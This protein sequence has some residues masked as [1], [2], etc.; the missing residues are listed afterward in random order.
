MRDVLLNFNN[1]L[2]KN[3]VKEKY[4]AKSHFIS[5]V[6]DIGDEYSSMNKKELVPSSYHN[7]HENPRKMM[8]TSDIFVAFDDHDGM[9]ANV[10]SSNDT[11]K[12]YFVQK[13]ESPD[14]YNLLNTKT[15]E[16]E[17]VA[18]VD[19]MKT[20]KMLNVHFEKI[21]MISRLKFK[22]KLTSNAHLKNKWIPFELS[23]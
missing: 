15:G 18:C 17:G 16:N 9:T 8:N 13:T 22:C 5:T 23:R 19:S 6:N 12:I 2:V 21:S 11:N 1:S 4:R 10:V 7:P 3:I 20:S 14:I